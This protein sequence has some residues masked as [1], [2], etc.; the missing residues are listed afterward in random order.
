MRTD[1]NNL[2]NSLFIILYILTGTLPNFSAIDILA[3]QWVYLTSLNIIVGIYIAFNI[4]SFTNSLSGIFKTWL[5]VL[6]TIYIVWAALSAFYAINV[7]ETLINLPRYFSV[8][9]A[10]VLAT[11]LLL[12]VKDP[13]LLVSRIL[14]L[15]LVSEILLYYNQ[16]SVQVASGTFD[17]VQLKGFSGNKNIAAASM[18]VKIPFLLYFYQRTSKEL[19]RFCILLLLALAYLALT[20]I[21]ARAALLSGTLIVL[22]FIAYN[23]YNYATRKTSI[24]KSLVYIFGVVFPFLVAYFGSQV[25]STVYNTKSYSDRVQTIAFNR[26]ASSGRFDY[27]ESAFQSFL[28]NPIFGSG[29]GNFKIKS[30]SYGADYIKGY[31]VPYHAHNDFIHTATELGIIGVICYTGVFVFLAIALL[32]MFQRSNN[33]LSH[34]IIIVALFLSLFA[35]GIDAFFNF[36]VARPLMQSA[37]ILVIGLILTLFVKKF[38]DKVHPKSIKTTLFIVSAI[39]FSIPALFLTVTQYNAMSQQ[40]RLLYE[41]NNAKYNY[42][43]TELDEISNDFPNLTETAMPIKAMKARYFY[44]NGKKEEAISLLHQSMKDNPYIRFPEN[45]LAQFYLNDQ[46]IDSAYHYSKIAFENLPNNMPHYDTYMK[47]LVLK[48]DLNSIDSAFERVRALA[49]DTET[50]WMIYLRSLAQT[51]SLGDP[52]AMQRASEGYNLFPQSNN[53]YFLYRVLTYG[54]INIT[55]ADQLSKEAEALYLEQKFDQAAL[56]YAEAA[57]LDGLNKSHALNSGIAFFMNKQYDESLPY[58]D[59]AMSAKR[60]DTAERALRFKALS[61]VEKGDKGS[62]CA[63]F[64][65][66]RDLYPKRM[67]QQEFQKYCINK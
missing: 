43:L 28:E 54:Q 40:G 27:W 49:G 30:I 38:G 4:P 60:D 67:Y 23:I 5:F 56:K 41:F 62:A 42:T 51:R 17:A 55:K 35:Y 63:L 26:S 12:H 46:K 36:P 10:V 18:A 21:Y 1:S 6:Y 59:I 39:L 64:V 25:L 32:R 50:I 37:L 9:I 61:L 52:F 2:I 45:L 7:A 14:S 34:Q 13:I 8:Y 33:N 22:L 66:L 3:P 47:S 29:L 53:V 20:I 31:T 15:F 48:K 57:N 58:F 19:I 16:F 24:E 65:R 44:N 11:T